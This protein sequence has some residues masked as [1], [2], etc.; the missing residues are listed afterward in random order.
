MPIKAYYHAHVLS[1]LNEDNQRLLGALAAEHHHAL[2]EQQ[3]WAWLQQI[4]ILKQALSGLNGD[5]FL[6]FY[7]PR[8]GK[9]AD[10][11]LV[12]SNIIFVIE[13]KPEQLILLR[14]PLSR[15]KTTLLT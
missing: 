7:I 9:R 3:R 12:S 11:V 14:A 15:S 8:M 2:E 6:E 5:I 10:T 13:F 1:F 4:S